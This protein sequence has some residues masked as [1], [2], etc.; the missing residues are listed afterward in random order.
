M[1]LLVMLLEQTALEKIEGFL[2][3]LIMEPHKY[4]L[5]TLPM[6]MSL[7]SRKQISHWK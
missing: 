4:G 1:V 2:R 5:A 7:M 3:Q 6:E